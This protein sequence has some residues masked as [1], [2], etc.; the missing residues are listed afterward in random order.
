MN[1]IY[2]SIFLLFIFNLFELS[3]CGNK[4]LGKQ[5][6]TVSYDENLTIEQFNEELTKLDNLQR[7]W[8]TMYVIAKKQGFIPQ[9]VEYETK[10]SQPSGSG[11]STARREIDYSQFVR[12]PSTYDEKKFNEALKEAAMESIK[13][14]K[15][16]DEMRG[17][18]NKALTIGGGP[19][20]KKNHNTS[21][22]KGKK[23]VEVEEEESE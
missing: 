18:A 19:S 7:D 23:V 20:S 13:L 5:G 17:D 10:P 11:Q 12:D 4:C 2:S 14:K 21:K 16:E 9:E 22:G 3:E 8:N 1:L 15:W 6:K